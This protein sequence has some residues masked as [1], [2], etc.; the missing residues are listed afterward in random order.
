MQA[1]IEARYTQLSRQVTAFAHHAQRSLIVILKVLGS[2]DRYSQ[3]L[4]V[5]C[6]GK[7]ATLVPH[8]AMTSTSTRNAAIIPVA[9]MML[10]F[11]NGCLVTP[12]SLET[13]INANS[14]S[15]N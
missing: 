14:P 15:L 11:G 4:G 5:T 1:A 6:L 3:H 10:S 9:F 13:V 2:H 7:R 8:T 12:S